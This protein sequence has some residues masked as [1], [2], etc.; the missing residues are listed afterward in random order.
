MFS[1]DEMDGRQRAIANVVERMLIQYKK[2]G[3][4]RWASYHDLALAIGLPPN[5]Q[6]AVAKT[7]AQLPWLHGVPVFMFSM[8]N[9]DGNFWTD[10]AKRQA[11]F[12]AVESR[13]RIFRWMLDLPVTGM[14]K[15][16]AEEYPMDAKMTL[17]ELKALMA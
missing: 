1:Y 16:T 4:F 7:C 10:W 15:D 12:Y 11:N 13:D 5:N 9:G 14:T 6:R 3:V 2:T 17:E 8:A